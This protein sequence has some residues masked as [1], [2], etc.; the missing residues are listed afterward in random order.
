MDALDGDTYLF[1]RF[2]GRECV[3]MKIDAQGFE[4]NVL[5]GFGAKLQNVLGIRL[6]TQLRS[7][8]KGQAL[9]RDIYEY[10]KSNGFILRDVRIT[11][12]FEYE[13]V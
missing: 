3:R 10:L 4:Y 6:E 11:Y 13:V 12:P 1:A 2:Y 5:R 7:L 9:F 8:Y